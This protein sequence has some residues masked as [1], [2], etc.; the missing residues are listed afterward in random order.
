MQH[1]ERELTSP[2]LLCDTKGLLNPEAIG[3]ASQP[4]V[5][6]NLR[7]QFPNK[8]KWNT[9]TVYGEEVLFTA[10]VAHFDIG[11]V[12]LIYFL[13][14]ETERFFE[15]RVALPFARHVKMPED[16]LS[17]MKFEDS[18]LSLHVIQENRK[19]H[20]SVSISDFDN[21]PLHADFHISHPADDE[22]VNVVVPKNR[23][24]FQF[25]A[26]H[27]ILPTSGILQIGDKRYEFNPDYSFTVYNCT[28]GI[29]PKSTDWQWGMAS[30]RSGGR[31]IG[32]NLGG[33]WSDGTGLTENAVIV[34]GS[35]TK[36][37]EDVIF[38]WNPER[39]KDRW[40][41]HTKF[42]DCVDLTFTPFFE[43][44]AEARRRSIRADFTQVFG[45]FNGSVKLDSGERLPIR[46]LLGSCEAFTAKW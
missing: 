37:H 46:R 7:G 24:V 30:Q 20:L 33:Q 35:M 41:I 22:S 45:Y 14:Y 13:D 11:A 44:T 18:R 2:V 9:W 36:I 27:H 5:R 43:R 32:L 42:T 23:S 28:R 38:S 21:E 26:K 31:R 19:S 12:C 15:K 4:I 34:D 8:K 3:Y 16:V 29:W 6:S 10:T 25:T 40:T 17:S 39:M 1:A